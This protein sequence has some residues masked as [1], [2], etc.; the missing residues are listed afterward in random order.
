MH[1]GDHAT[2]G[3]RIRRDSSMVNVSRLHKQFTPMDTRPD[4]YLL[5]HNTA[6]ATHEVLYQ[7]GSR[8]K[9]NDFAVRIYPS[10]FS[11]DQSWA[12]HFD[13]F[14]TAG[15]GVLYHRELY[16]EVRSENRKDPIE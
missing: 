16:I 1:H 6:E 2:T 9:R 3:L 12:E 14:T 4:L 8:E 11:A 15:N 13:A 10:Q 7:E 5:T